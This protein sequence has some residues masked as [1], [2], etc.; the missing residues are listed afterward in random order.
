MPA[1]AHTGAIGE[2]QEGSLIW[3]AGR[4]TRFER[5][6]ILLDDGSGPARIYFPDDLPWRRPYVNVGEF[7]A[8]Q[9]VVSQYV[10]QPPRTGGYRII[11][12]FATDVSSA[13]LFLPVTGVSCDARSA[14]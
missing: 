8:A 9:G 5:S 3:I 13:P 11:P 4:V 7:W 10:Q 1:R 14:P 6:A 12:R 2:P